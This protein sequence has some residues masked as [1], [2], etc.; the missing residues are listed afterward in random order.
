MSAQTQSAPLTSIPDIHALTPGQAAQGLPV[1]LEGTV[2]FVQPRDSSLFIQ[3]NNQGIYVDFDKNIGLQPGDRVALTGK[4][5]T[6]FKTD[7]NASSVQ[8]LDHGKLPLAPEAGFADLIDSKFDGELVKVR[9]HI[10]SATR[11]RGSVYSDLRFHL[12][13]PDGMIEGEIAYPGNLS[14]EQLLDADVEMTGVAGGAF[15]SKMQMGGVWLDIDSPDQVTILQPAAAD[16]WSIPS[17]PLDQVIQAYRL[18]DASKRVRI[19]G[20]LTYFEPGA[21]A[22]IQNDGRS[23]LLNTGTT[24]PM[25]TGT[26]VEAIGFPEITDDSVWMNHAQ[27]RSLK[28]TSLIKPQTINWGDASQGKFAYDLVSMEGEIVGTVHDSRVDLFIIKADGHLFSATLRHSSSDATQTTADASLDT[29]TKVR[30]TG[31]CFTDPGNHWRDRLWFDVRMRSLNDIAVV[32]PPS[33]WTVRR[34]SIAVTILSVVILLAVIWAGLLDRRLR[35]QTEVLARQSQEDAIRERRRARQEQQRSRILELISSSE[36]LPNVLNDIQGIVTARLLGA[37]CWIEL[38]T[39]SGEDPS[40]GTQLP[41][42]S[43][44]RIL[45]SPDGTVLGY[46]RSIPQPKATSPQEVD[47]VMLAGACLAELAIDTRRLYTDLRRRSEFDLLTDVPNRFSMERKLD[48]LML[49]ANS[50]HERF[51]LIYVDLDHFKDVNDQYGH[52]IGDLYLKEVTK[53]MKLQ[54]RSHDFLARIGGDEFIALTPVSDGR[55]DA[56]EIAL[57]LQRSFEEPFLIE[58]IQ[59]FGGAS[60]GLAIYPEDGIN[61]EDLQKI[62]DTAMYTDKESKRPNRRGDSRMTV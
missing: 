43:V 31:I 6:S 30:V 13:V 11:D 24:E 18:G 42:G 5:V 61:K 50:S 39:A 32:E 3:E 19:T 48:Q 28:Q 2:T 14:P 37:R 4:T 27:L 34:L 51:G 46:L 8:L 60:I 56:E 62:A 33:L 22:V 20:T 25:H 40:A 59:L 26:E 15:D 53:R 10:I 49:A 52:R 41:A 54:L 23:L 16:P 17:V 58:G 38:P 35:R 21:V 57:R 1:Q 36:P 45:K 55:A 9:G 7:V 47:D 12:K 44:T 29:G